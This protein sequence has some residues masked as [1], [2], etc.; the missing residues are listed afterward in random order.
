MSTNP[1]PLFD[2]Q[3][4]HANESLPPGTAAV[5]AERENGNATPVRT[6]GSRGWPVLARLVAGA[7]GLAAALIVLGT[8]P[9]WIRGWYGM[10]AVV[11]I[12]PGM[13][14]REL[15]I[16]EPVAFVLVIAGAAVGSLAGGFGLAHAGL[17]GLLLLA[18]ALVIDLA[19]ELSG[20]ASVGGGADATGWIGA[21][22]PLLGVGVLAAVFVVVLLILPLPPV[23]AIVLVAPLLVLAAAALAFGRRSVNN[24]RADG[25]ARPRVGR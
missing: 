7:C 13:L 21:V 19:D 3:G 5:S 14:R 18:Y 22:A 2:S 8:L 10:V 12:V 23:S 15:A 25:A 16:V 20:S 6:S 17:V 1:R 9:G 4:P 24:S 11:L